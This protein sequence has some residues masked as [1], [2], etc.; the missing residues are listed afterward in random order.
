M[1]QSA[2]HRVQS[3]ALLEAALESD[4]KTDGAS[5]EAGIPRL[6]FEAP[7]VSSSPTGGPPFVVTRDGHR[8]LVLAEAEKTAS[9]PLEVLVNWR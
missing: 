5:F 9:E 1:H 7:T 6:L 8:L 3:E 4:V 2:L